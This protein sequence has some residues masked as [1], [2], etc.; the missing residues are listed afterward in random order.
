MQRNKAQKQDDRSECANFDPFGAH[1]QTKTKCVHVCLQIFT[2]THN[3]TSRG[4]NALGSGTC[5]CE[6]GTGGGLGDDSFQSVRVICYC[7][8]LLV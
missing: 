2:C 5:D 8:P 4:R 1:T 7:F 6:H 3:L